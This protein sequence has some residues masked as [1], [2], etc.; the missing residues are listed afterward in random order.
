MD[1]LERSLA[2]HDDLGTGYRVRTRSRQHL[3]TGSATTRSAFSRDGG[4][5]Q[6][7]AVSIR[8]DPARYTVQA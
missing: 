5:V 6:A 8:H 2:G 1:G 7:T 3:T 4:G